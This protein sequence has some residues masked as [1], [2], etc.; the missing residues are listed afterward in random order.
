MQHYKMQV[1][2]TNPHY[3]AAV[4]FQCECDAAVEPHLKS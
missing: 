4:Y 2:K 3:H 1:I